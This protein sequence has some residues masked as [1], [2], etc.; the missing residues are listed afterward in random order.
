[1]VLPKSAD[2]DARKRSDCEIRSEDLLRLEIQRV[3]LVLLGPLWVCD[4][5]G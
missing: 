5:Q 1:M 2:V 3:L 4:C